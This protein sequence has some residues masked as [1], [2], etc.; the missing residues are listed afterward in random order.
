V[1]EYQAVMIYIAMLV[2]NNFIFNF[3]V[4][5]I[6]FTLTQLFPVL[7]MFSPDISKISAVFYNLGFVGTPVIFN[8]QF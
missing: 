5:I 2:H 8:K 4:N 6:M 1:Y 3:K 7:Y